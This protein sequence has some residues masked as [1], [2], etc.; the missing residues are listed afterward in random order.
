M[1]LHAVELIRL[2]LPL[3]VSL[4]T[5]AGEH[6]VRPIVLVR[7]ITD[8]GEGYGECEALAEP[9]YTEEY[10]DGAARVLA[11]H[12]VPRLL[13]GGPLEASSPAAA[14]LERLRPVRGHRMAKA[15]VEMALLDAWLRGEG[16]SLADFLGATSRHVPAGATV[17]IVPTAEVL[18]RVAAAAAA[19]YRRV[20]LKI[21]PGHDV[22][23][24]GAVRAEFPA[25][26]LAADANGAYRL[27]DPGDRRALELI[28]G[29]GLAALEQPLA[30]EDLVGHAELAAAL[31]TPV[32]LDESVADE[33]DLQAALALGACVGVSLKAARLGGLL[34]ACR[35][36]DRCLAAGVRMAAGG[37]LET[38]LGRAASLALA[39]CPG[40]DLPG[41]L[42][43]SERYFV[44]D[45]TPAHRVVDGELAVPDG[46]GLGV[47]PRPDVLAATRTGAELI[48][49]P[50]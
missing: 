2:E 40:F 23:P 7:L 17:G 35:V 41:D 31:V 18:G 42:G 13:A 45:L 29:L 3:V 47:E 1:E 22:E 20:K 15:A 48:R 43:G 21:G 11:D 8:S 46:P 6:A 14:G 38:G 19:G 36:R 24:I 26:V 25:L 50:S 49:A 44:P 4:A 9:I 39:G 12:L 34:A 5:S 27:D 28:D 10:A 33:Q 32:V 30:A 37:M 16:R